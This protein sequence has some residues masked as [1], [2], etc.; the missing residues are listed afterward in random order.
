MLRGALLVALVFAATGCDRWPFST[1]RGE[2]VATVRPGQVL[3]GEPKVGVVYQVDLYTHCG[4]RHVEFA[5]SSW[6]IRGDL[7]DGANPPRDF[8][9]PVD[10]GTISLTSPDEATYVSERG[11]VRELTK[12]EGLPFV[13]GCR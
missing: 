7:G 13:Q 6:A 4:L 10:H 2:P 8:G 9:N 5:G 1:P 3:V 12:G 11:G